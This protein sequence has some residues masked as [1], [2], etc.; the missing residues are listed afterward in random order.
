MI[1]L[2]Y[3][4]CCYILDIMNFAFRNTRHTKFAINLYLTPPGNLTQ[5]LKSATGHGLRNTC[6][7]EHHSFPMQVSRIYNRQNILKPKNKYTSLRQAGIVFRP[8]CTCISR[9]RLTGARTEVQSLW[10]FEH[11]RM[12]M[13]ATYQNVQ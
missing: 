4:K 3:V 10:E 2:I 7:L 6:Y 9:E 8:R 13:P 1:Y 12:N 11:K 5:T